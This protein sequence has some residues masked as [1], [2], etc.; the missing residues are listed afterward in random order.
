MSID[1]GIRRIVGDHGVQD[2]YTTVGT[3]RLGAA[4]QDRRR[5]TIGPAVKDLFQQI[6]VRAGRQRL[7]KALADNCHPIGHSSRLED[8]AGESD[9]PRE[10]DQRSM[11]LGPL[12]EESPRAWLRYLLRRPPHCAPGPSRP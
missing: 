2:E 3:G 11:D 12:C 5:F 4:T 10:I 1:R 8:L 7:E 9:G 6:E